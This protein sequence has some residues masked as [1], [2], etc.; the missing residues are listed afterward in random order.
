MSAG[1]SSPRTLRTRARPEATCCCAQSCLASKCRTSP[2]PS[3]EATAK[4]ALLSENTSNGKLILRRAAS[5]WKKTPSCAPRWKPVSSAS[6]LGWATKA[7]VLKRL[8][9]TQP[10]TFATT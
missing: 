10:Q 8:A 3:L 4:P 5:F 7:C 1:L 2:T 6:A 9:T